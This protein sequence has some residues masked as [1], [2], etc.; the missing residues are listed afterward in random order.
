[1]DGEMD[2]Q[3]RSPH[4]INLYFGWVES[5]TS[6]GP[7]WCAR[8]ASS[9]PSSAELPSLAVCCPPGSSSAPFQMK[10][11]ISGSKQQEEAT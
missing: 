2:R 5:V 4:K 8:S 3:M 10:L 6:T 1:M 11:N 9:C 7:G